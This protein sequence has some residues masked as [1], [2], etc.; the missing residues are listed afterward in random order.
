MK[1][2]RAL[3]LAEHMLQ[4][5]ESGADSWPLHLVTELYVFGSFA[6]GATE[7]HDLDIYVEVDNS[8]VEW[9]E[10][11]I[12]ELSIHRDPYALLRRSLGGNHRGYQF[13][14]EGRA[15][16]DFP[17]TPL[18][19]RGEP[20]STA[21]RRLHA[22]PADPDAGRAPRD[23]M[24]PELDGL[25]RWIPRTYREHLAHAVN[26]GAVRLERIEL[27]D[28]PV[29]NAAAIDHIDQRWKPTSPLHRAAR[30]VVANLEQRGIDPAHVHLHGHDIHDPVTPYFAGFKLRHF[31]AIPR[32]LSQQHASNGSKSYTPH[33]PHHCTPYESSPPNPSCS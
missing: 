25:D 15:K 29:H 2:E 20:V 31:P 24:L 10:H 9:L 33:I 27:A 30:A 32:C 16:F 18:W 12:G 26:G 5:L 14:F 3:E 1:R 21:V 4:R 7:P 13:L 17:L 22:I 11:F 8:D 19:R 28:A 6:R 23:A